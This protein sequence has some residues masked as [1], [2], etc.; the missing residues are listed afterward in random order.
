MSLPTYNHTLVT[1]FINYP[2]G[3]PNEK[4]D[5]GLALPRES[6]IEDFAFVGVPIFEK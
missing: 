1:E 6:F 3:L 5:E 2:E 4:I